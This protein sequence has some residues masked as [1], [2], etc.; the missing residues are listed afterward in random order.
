VLEGEH[1]RG[2]Q[3]D[4]LVEHPPSTITRR[5]DRPNLAAPSRVVARIGYQGPNRLGWAR[6]LDGFLMAGACDGVAATLASTPGAMAGYGLFIRI[7]DDQRSRPATT[8]A[9]SQV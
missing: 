3:R 5:L 9:L 4:R 8:F 1:H 7:V 2:T 6:D